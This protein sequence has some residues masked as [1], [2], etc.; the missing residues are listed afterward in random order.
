MSQITVNGKSGELSINSLFQIIFDDC[1]IRDSEP[2]IIFL[3]SEILYYFLEKKFLIKFQNKDDFEK[4][5]RL[6]N[7][8]F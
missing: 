5:K 1:R 3:N 4:V 7:F 6:C 8:Y 2:N